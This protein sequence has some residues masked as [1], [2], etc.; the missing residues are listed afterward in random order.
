M[1][2]LKKLQWS[3]CFSYGDNNEIVFDE[4]P[5][6]QLVGTNGAG[7]T[8]IS[9]LLQEILYGKNIKNIKKQDITNNKS[10]KTGYSIVLYFEKDG[11]DYEI[12]LNR[13][14]NLKLL[15]FK[16]GFDI[17][18]HTSLNT[19]KT[20]NEIVGVADFKVFCQLIYQHSTDSLDFLTATDTNRKRFL[21]S[22]LQL[23]KYVE[24]HERFK[25]MV[26]EVNKE[27]AS[28]SGTIETLESWINRHKDMDLIKRDLI[29]VPPTPVNEYTEQKD[30]QT[31]LASINSINKRIV[32]NNQYI[33][34]LERL[35][36]KYYINPAPAAPNPSSN[37]LRTQI[38]IKES[39]KQGVQKKLRHLES[40]PET[41]SQCF[42][43]INTKINSEMVTAAKQHI[44][45]LDKD[46]DEL[47]SLHKY[48]LEAEGDRAKY[49][50][51]KNDFER[52]SSAIDKDLPLKTLDKNEL[53]KRLEE[54]SLQ[55][56]EAEALIKS[57]EAENLKISAH[58]SKVDV[59]RNQ[60]KEFSEDLQNKD[61]EL[62]EKENL[63]NILELLKKTFGTNG[64]VSYKIESSVKELEKKINKYLSELSYFQ[65]YFKLAGEKL[66]IEVVDDAG[67]V[68]SISN[69]SSG[70]RARVN[71]A[72]ILAI[73]SILSSLTSTKINLLF[74]DE[75]IG[76]IDAEGKEKL[77]EVLLQ[78]NLNTFIVSHDWNHPL[79]PRIN[80]IK[81]HNISRIEDG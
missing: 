58:N 59:I 78:E 17:S 72:T 14:S 45:I 23:E 73:R 55:I 12:H 67:N 22:L 37:E 56:S 30:I 26:T 43:K 75:V 34:E 10:G 79:I 53:T 33:S 9:L 40:L 74:L 19:Y 1:L 27:V 47:N 16:D 6:T 20:I 64:L 65:I 46:I 50:K 8:S 61:V 13:K 11:I 70:E 68:T 51:A 57:T 69:L 24:M 15:L 49:L 2:T 4:N 25:K 48:A 31:K 7:K 21:I 28:L 44:A 29:P 42:Q 5:L 76:V 18:S 38:R 62:I 80:I 36:S 60:L 71:I 41:C 77:A 54:L 66:N 39:E 3:N 32:Q 35:D 63:V 81:E 52:L